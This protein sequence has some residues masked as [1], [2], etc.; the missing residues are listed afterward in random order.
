MRCLAPTLA[1]A[2]LAAVSPAQL[3]VREYLI[4]RAN[5]FPHDPAVGADGI[6]WYTDQSNSY[7]GRFDPV[8]EQFVDYATPTPNS[9]PHGITVA[10]DGFVWYTAQ[11]SGRLGRVDPGSGGITEYVLPANAN[12]P[13]TPLAHQGAIWFTAQTNDTYGRFDPATVQTGVFNAPSGSRPYGIAPAPDGSLWIALFGTNRL[14]RVDVSTGALTT[15]TLPS[16]GSRPRRIVVAADGRVYYTDFAR[17]YLGRYDPATAA[18]REWQ[19]PAAQPYGI[20][21]GTDSR[22]WFHASASTLMV[23]FDPR[24]EQ[25]QTVTIPTAGCTVRHM[26]WDTT[27]GRLWLA[28]SG[29][30]R[31]GKIEL[32]APTATVGTGCPGG[33][34]VPRITS[35]GLPRIGTTTSIAV[36]DTAAPLAVL[37]AGA[38]TTTW[39][40]L[41][42]PLDL[43][44]I[45]APGC[46]VHSSWEV[47]V[48]AGA[49]G[50][51]PVPI[52]LD[53]SL[54]GA[55][56]SWQWALTGEPGFVLTTTASLRT[57]IVGV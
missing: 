31:L 45:G 5:A 57:T 56:L 51:V 21:T 26:T 48:F 1:L 38:S 36:A 15:V 33:L 49:P 53:P 54:G 24:T 25:M 32:G 10:P 42:L 46:R 11:D 35:A 17:G 37:F 47:V 2:A 55:A 52:P 7:I 41:P 30:R 39:N 29:T 23:A 18:F 44:S 19:A 6:A 22:I 4:P 28:L 27:R 20:W 9:G 34:G 50:A 12:R 14:G 8:L 3:S 13:H 16:S 43:G 40:G